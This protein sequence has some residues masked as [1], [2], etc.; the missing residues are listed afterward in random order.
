MRRKAIKRSNVRYAADTAF[1][2]DILVTDVVEQERL[3]LIMQR[4]VQTQMS[5]LEAGLSIMENVI[6][7]AVARFTSTNQV[8]QSALIVLHMDV[9]PQNSIIRK[10]IDTSRQ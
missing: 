6:V 7:G 4:H 10:N 5:P 3:W 8:I 1:M 9:L 2:Q